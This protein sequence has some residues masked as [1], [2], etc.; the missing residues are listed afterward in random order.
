MRILVT[1]AAGFIGSHYV[2]AMLSG[3]YAG[4]EQAD[5][6]VLDKLTYAGNRANLPAKH[7]RL[8]FVHGDTPCRKRWSKRSAC[9]P[10]TRRATRRAG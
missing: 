3:E 7:P 5:I 9:G 2:R 8:T 1:G 6:T 4:Y 10:P